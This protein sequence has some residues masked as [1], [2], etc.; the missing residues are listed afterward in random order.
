MAEYSNEQYIR[1]IHEYGLNT[2]TFKDMLSKFR[3]EPEI[4][5]RVYR[6]SKANKKDH[7]ASGKP[8]PR[9]NYL[10]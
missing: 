3:F 7:W 8:R 5:F 2:N 10:M 4:S 1:K 9:T 6:S